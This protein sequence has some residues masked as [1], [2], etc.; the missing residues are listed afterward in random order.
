MR[1]FICLAAYDAAL[2][3]RIASG[4][5]GPAADRASA[6]TAAVSIEIF[7]KASLVHDDIEDDDAMRY[8]RPTMHRV[9]GIPS[10]INAGDYLLG[11]G[12]RLIAGLGAACQDRDI[13]VDLLQR[14]GKLTGNDLENN[15]GLVNA[16]DKRLE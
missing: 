4:R 8:G 6:R 1:P 11:L 12:Y 5:Q 15:P 3:D 14:I 2:A 9:H 16:P 10:A 13:V 7:H